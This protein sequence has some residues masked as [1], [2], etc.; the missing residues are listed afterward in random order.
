VALFDPTNNEEALLAT[1]VGVWS[2]DALSGSSTVWGPSNSGLAN[3]RVD[4]LQLRAS[5][6]LLLQQH[7]AGDCL[8]QMHS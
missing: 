1:E 4:M 8:L 6:S 5:D 7:M 3:V 2:T